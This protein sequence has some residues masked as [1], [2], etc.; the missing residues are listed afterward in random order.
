MK[1]THKAA[2]SASLCESP[3]SQ[4]WSQRPKVLLFTFDFLGRIKCCSYSALQAIRSRKDSVF[5]STG[6]G[7]FLFNQSRSTKPFAYGLPIKGKGRLYNTWSVRS[8]FPLP[9]LEFNT[10]SIL[11]T[12]GLSVAQAFSLSDQCGLNTQCG[13]WRSRAVEGLKHIQC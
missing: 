7:T 2:L 4:R 8:S 9:E 13:E 11:S 10:R 5:L 6:V 3:K 12:Y 1:K